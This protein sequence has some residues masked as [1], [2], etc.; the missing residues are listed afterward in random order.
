MSPVCVSSRHSVQRDNGL[1][2]GCQNHYIE[3]ASGVRR[4]SRIIDHR[5]VYASF[6]NVAKVVN[7]VDVLASS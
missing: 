1:P 7:L 5:E 6:W 2:K 3:A 4:G